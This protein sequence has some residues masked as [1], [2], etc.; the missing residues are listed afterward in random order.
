MQKWLAQLNL[1][2]RLGYAGL[3]PFM[4]TALGVLVGV[5]GSEALFKLYSV[6]I[7]A[8]MAGACWGALQSM[9]EKAASIDLLLSIGTSLWALMI[10]FIPF[11]VAVP[12]LVIGY[13]LLLW[14]DTDSNVASHYNARYSYL[15]KVLTGVVISL[16]VL[17]FLFS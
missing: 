17:V 11:E 6:V 4:L 13:G 9:G 15:R 3:L 5:E 7:L 16:H 1:T 8:F 14:L 12:L 2:E 10:Y